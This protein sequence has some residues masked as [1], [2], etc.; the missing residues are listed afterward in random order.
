MLQPNT[1]ALCIIFFF[2]NETCKLPER[3]SSRKKNF[4]CWNF[5]STDTLREHYLKSINNLRKQIAQGSADNKSGKCPAGKNIY[6]VQSTCTPTTI[7]KKQIG[8]W[9]TKAVKDAGV[10]NPPV[11]KAGLEDFAKLANGKATRIGCAQKNCNEQLYVSCVVNEPAPAVN[12][13][14]YETGA[15]C[16]TNNECTT[17]LESK[18]KNKVCIAGHPGDNTI[19]PQNQV[20]TDKIRNIFWRTH[21]RLRRQLAQGEVTMGNGAKARQASKMRKMVYNCAA[22]ASARSSAVQ[23]RSSAVSLADYAENLYVIPSNT[24]EHK[25]AAR[26]AANGWWSEIDTHFMLQSDF[27]RNLYSSSLGIQNFTNMAWETHEKFGCAIVRCSSKTNVVC[28]YTPKS[29]GEGKQIYKMGPMC[30]RCHDYPGTRCVDGLCT[31]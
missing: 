24:I 1:E 26:M 7:L 6:K 4:Q 18:C 14:I 17:F 9:W 13:A 8:E 10:D 19:C 31:L 2:L 23:C 11:N 5:K 16:S 12:M 27:Q 29:I 20:I 30:R 21:N 22:E 3:S 28:H 15:G 25:T